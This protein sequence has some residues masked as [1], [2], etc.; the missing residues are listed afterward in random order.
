IRAKKSI[1]WKTEKAA[2]RI[3]IV[4]SW[5]SEKI[6]KINKSITG[7]IDPALLWLWHRLAAAAPN[8]P[9]AWEP[10]D[11]TGVALKKKKERKKRKT[12]GVEIKPKCMCMRGT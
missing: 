3:N 4:K 5:F 12:G 1:K 10:P 11:V 8:P 2:K 9:P 7:L 6:N